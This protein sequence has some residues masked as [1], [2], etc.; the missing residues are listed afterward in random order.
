M[1][2]R[3]VRNTDNRHGA[4]IALVLYGGAS[5][6]REQ[7]PSPGLQ[8]S[9]RNLCPGKSLRKMS[10]TQ[11]HVALVAADF[12]LRA[13]AFG[14]AVGLDTHH[15]DGLAPAVADRLELHEVVGLGQQLGAARKQLAA[16]VGA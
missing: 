7:L 6:N 13:F 1:R 15:H 11:W 8:T 14:G 3:R 4:A 2:L 12:D 10:A 16:K 5:T 9:G